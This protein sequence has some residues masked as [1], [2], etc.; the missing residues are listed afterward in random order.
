MQYF[1]SALDIHFRSIDIV[2][3]GK[4]AV[5]CVLSEPASYYS[6]IVLD[7]SM[8]VMDGIEACE[9]ILKYFNDQL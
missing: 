3:N 4:I 5:D 8:P 7:I 1:K 9:L 2:S 6:V